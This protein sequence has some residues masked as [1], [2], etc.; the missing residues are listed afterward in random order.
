[1]TMDNFVALARVLLLEKLQ[2]E[3]NENPEDKKI[4]QNEIVALNSTTRWL[5]A[6]YSQF[7]RK[8]SKVDVDKALDILQ[9]EPEK[10]HVHYLFLVNYLLDL[11]NVYDQLLLNKPAP[12]VRQR[13]KKP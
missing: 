12:K 2:I 9:N 1:M 6:K 13:R 11:E 4:S 7:F 3:L 10:L 5:I 8:A